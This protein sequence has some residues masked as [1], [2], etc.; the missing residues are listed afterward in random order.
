MSLDETITKGIAR[1]A[2]EAERAETPAEAV[3]LE[4]VDLWYDLYLA[5]RHAARG[6]WSMGCE[7]TV[8][9]IITL[10]RVL[11]RGTSWRKVVAPLLVDGIWQAVHDAAG[12]EV[13]PPDMAAVEADLA[14]DRSRG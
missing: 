10:T 7:N 8:G 4:L 5:R 12:V 2:E 6:G 9:R 13:D 11:D 3:E 14:A 1:A